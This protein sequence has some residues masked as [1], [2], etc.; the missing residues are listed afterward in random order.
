MN[1]IIFFFSEGDGTFDRPLM[2]SDP[3]SIPGR[4]GAKDTCPRCG[5]Q[6]FH[7]EKML[8]KNNVSAQQA[9]RRKSTSPSNPSFSMQVFHK[10]CF[11]CVECRRPL[12]STSCCDSP[13]GE[14]YCRGCYGKIFGPKGYGYGGS[15][16]MPA[17]MAPSGPAA[18]QINMDE[19][20]Q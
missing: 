7:A 13:D 6:V 20:I 15:G 9:W 11:T 10:Q 5:G 19:R 16:S 3:A 17:L 8:S 1:L 2:S 12:D 4:D 18:A 14:I